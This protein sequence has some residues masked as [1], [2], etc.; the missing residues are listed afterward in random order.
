MSG[1]QLFLSPGLC[2]SLRA[3]SKFIFLPQLPENMQQGGKMRL[4]TIDALNKGFGGDVEELAMAVHRKTN[5]PRKDIH[6]FVQI[7]N[8]IGY[9]QESDPGVQLDD[10]PANNTGVAG[11]QEITLITPLS[12]VTQSGSYCLFSHE[13]TLQLRLTQAEFDALRGFNV[14]TTVAAARRQYLDRELADGLSEEQFDNLVARMAGTG[15]FIAARELEDDTETE[16]F[17]TVDRR[18]LQSLVDAR[19]AAHDERVARDGSE[20]VQVVPVNTVHGT[21]PASLGLVVAYAM[22]YQGGKLQERYEFVP[23]FM[24]DLARISARARRPGV[25]LFSNYLWNSDDNL[26]LSAAVKE[27]NPDNI[28]IH[29]GPNTP[30][31]EQDCADFFVEHPHVDITVRQEGE[32]TLADL[33]DKLQLPES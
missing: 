27:A 4:E 14:V 10:E 21:T 31:Y 3:G 12:F 30:A 33:L 13:G 32:A 8:E 24:T 19:I 9:L 7:L 23:M 18:E 17:G 25:F 11:E 1:K 20:R 6:A 26:R 29:G 16:L 2:L 22:D 28:T 5:A 15:L